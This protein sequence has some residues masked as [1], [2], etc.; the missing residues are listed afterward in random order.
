[1]TY[2]PVNARSELVLPTNRPDGG[3]LE[4]TRMFQV[5]SAASILPAR[6][7]TRGSGLGAAASMPPAGAGAPALELDA[8]CEQAARDSS[9]RATP[10]RTEA[11]TDS[12]MGRGQECDEHFFHPGD[13]GGLIDVDIRGELEHQL[14][15]PGAVGTEQLLHHGHGAAVMLDH[16]GE[17]Q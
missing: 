12:L 3:V 1:M 4:R 8:G 11:M 10:W 7:P 9:V 13:L 2:W 6:R 14:V 16:E 15:H 17:K 5:A